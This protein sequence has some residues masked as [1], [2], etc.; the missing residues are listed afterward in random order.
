MV[1]KYPQREILVPY[2]GRSASSYETLAGNS[3][4]LT[5]LIN[6]ETSA[7]TFRATEGSVLR[8]MA[9]NGEGWPERLVPSSYYA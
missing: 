4:S 2:P 7:K 3:S 6:G 1:D 8:L 5:Y 9:K